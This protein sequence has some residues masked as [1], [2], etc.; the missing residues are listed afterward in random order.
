M[1]PSGEWM[2]EFFVEKGHLFAMVLR[3]ERDR[4]AKEAR[5]IAGLLERHG[6]PRGSRIIELGCGT[7]RVAVPLAAEGYRVACLDIS[8]DYV[9]EAKKYARRLGVEDRLEPVAGD[10]WRLDELVRGP[11]DAA[12]LVWSTLIGYRE[13]PSHD[14]ELL[15]KVHGMVRGGGK[16]LILRQVDRDTVVLRHAQ[17]PS[18]TI[19]S[20]L[21][22]IMVF[23]RP[24]FDPVTSILENTWTYYAREPGGLRLLGSAGFR[25][26]IY[27]VTELVELARE[28]GWT[29]E[30]LYSSLRGEPYRPGRGVNAVFTRNP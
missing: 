12:L 9:E 30:A 13:D 27:T 29:L 3:A 19:V 25:M 24:R 17:C 8:P 28:A 7:G 5:L 11:Y 20:D 1:A 18:D 21:G 16:L 10:A 2:R 22:D 26:R 23:E 15:R 14:R 6:V 4:G